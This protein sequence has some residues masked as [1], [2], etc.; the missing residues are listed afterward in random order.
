MKLLLATIIEVPSEAN[1]VLV[2][3]CIKQESKIAQ[4]KYLCRITDLLKFLL[5]IDCNYLTKISCI[6][7]DCKKSL[8]NIPS[9]LLTIPNQFN[10]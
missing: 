6:I 8:N 4:K 1:F 9:N 2:D 3:D 5:I 7:P 10:L